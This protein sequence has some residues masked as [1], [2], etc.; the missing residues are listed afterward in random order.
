[1]SDGGLT[2]PPG[3]RG[4][5]PVDGEERPQA[6]AAR[7]PDS[8]NQVARNA[9]VYGLGMLASR[10]VSFIMLPVYTHQLS[11]ADYGLMSLLQVI[12]DVVAILSTAGATAGVMRFYFKTNDPEQRRR[13]IGT[14]HL[15]LAGLGL[16]GAII[17]ATNAHWVWRHFLDSAGSTT[18]LYIAA[19]TFVF[20]SLAGVPMAFL[21]AEGRSVQ[22]ASVLVAKLFMQ[23]TLNI[24]F[25]VVLDFAV[26]GVLLS[27]LISSAIIGTALTIFLIRRNGLV[28]H[29]PAA[30]DLRRF[31][32]PYQLV[33]AGTFVLAFGDRFFLQAY[34]G[35]AEVGLYS[36][37]CQ[38][39]FLL[40]GSVAAP[41]MRAWLPMRFRGLAQPGAEREA[42]D[43]QG[44]FYL[45]LV[46]ITA[47]AGLAIFVR[48]TLRIMAAPAYIEA[49]RYVPIILFAYLFQVWNDTVSFGVQVAER[50]K[51]VTL[52][53]WI[54]VV[55]VVLLYWLLIPRFGAMGAAV[56]T[57]VSFFIRFAAQYTFSQRVFPM[58][59]HW[60]RP[61]LILAVAMVAAGTAHVIPTRSFWVELGAGSMLFATYGA[62][63][64]F[65]VMKRSERA[66]VKDFVKR[67]IRR[68]T[69]MAAPPGQ[70]PSEA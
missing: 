54:S 47:A 68:V 41:F 27:S 43:S 61:L 45:S 10:L 67:R 31:G 20:D 64:W 60:A 30:A 4:A 56:A 25:L 53:T 37:A 58:P 46:V 32:F 34:Q 23:L 57:L 9:I 17:L 12:T 59:Y 48:P 52:A 62:L 51:W 42:R 66:E 49:A 13:L 33:T 28:W 3:A 22:Y 24:L 8:V 6:P 36:L 2:G 44:F 35:R 5:S 50:T 11:T 7:T 29:R 21:Q 1:M 40:T 15:V 14:A 18:L 70:L 55:S 38:F 26:G 63:M 39:G 19:V 69:G 16:T 65:Q